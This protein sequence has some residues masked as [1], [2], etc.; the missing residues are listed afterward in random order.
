MT[1]EETAEKLGITIEEVFRRAYAL[2]GLIYGGPGPV[3][4][5][6][7]YKTWHTPPLYV[8]KFCHRWDKLKEALN[9]KVP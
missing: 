8:L 3:A 9:G 5:L 7:H 1:P 6:E 4:D 2:Y